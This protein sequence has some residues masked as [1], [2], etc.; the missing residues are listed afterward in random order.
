MVATRTIALLAACLLGACT[1][2]GMSGS[3]TY[4]GS[5]GASATVINV[6]LSS[7]PASSVS[8]GTAGGYA[9]ATT[10][11][12]VG[13]SIRFINTDS[14]AHTASAVGG[15]TF[16]AGSPLTNA[17]TTSSGS[18]ISGTWSS[19]TLQAGQASQTILVDKAGTYLYGCFFHY[20][21]PMRGEIVAF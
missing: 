3:G 15:T 13:G 19:G 1:P 18:M 7:Y 12:A 11:I 20:G 6:N 21:A 14:F 4:G 10:T 16:P 8:A 2:G 5:G 17:A 9:P